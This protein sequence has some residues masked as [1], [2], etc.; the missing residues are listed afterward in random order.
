M[1]ES[2]LQGIESGACFALSSSDEKILAD[3]VILMIVKKAVR[4]DEFSDDIVDVLGITDDIDM[5]NQFHFH[6]TNFIPSKVPDI[7][8]RS[9][10]QGSSA[11]LTPVFGNIGVESSMA[12]CVGRGKKSLIEDDFNPMLNNGPPSQEY[13]RLQGSQ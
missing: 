8:T 6:G 3:K 11:Q 7:H 5:I 9:M 4:A 12:G 13:Q 1:S 2:L 10:F